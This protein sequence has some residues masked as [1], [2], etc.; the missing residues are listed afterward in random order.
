MLD[1][2]ATS[3]TVDEALLKTILPDKIIKHT[4]QSMISTQFDGKK[5]ACHSYIK[6][7]RLKF[8]MN[9]GTYNPVIQHFEPSKSTSYFWT[10]FSRHN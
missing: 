4:N 10:Q 9:C 8:Y 2:G 7:A 5:L 6:N 3:L 1:S